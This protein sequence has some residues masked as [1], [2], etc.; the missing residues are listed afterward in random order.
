MG[1]ARFFVKEQYFDF[2]NREP[3]TAGWDYWTGQITGCGADTNCTRQHR[4]DVSNAFFFELEYQQTG[5]FV[6]RLYRAAYGNTQP[7][8]NSESAALPAYSAFVDDRSRIIGGL[9]LATA[10]LALANAFV[11]RAAF[12]TRYPASLTSAQFVDAVLANIQTSTGA[13]L[14]TQRTLLINL[15]DISGR[16]AVMYRLVDDSS[17]NPIANSAFLNAEYN[18]AFVLTQYFGYLR[19]DTDLAG[20]NFWLG[21][22]NRFPLRSA[23]GQNAMVCA[24]ITATEYQQRFNANATRANSEC[25]AVP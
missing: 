16:G 10:Q 24:F 15:A 3:D 13:D 9:N 5:A 20:F 8:P 22:V 19:R 17:S 12:T 21:I 1:T 14:T 6:Y 25:P 7:M 11:Q 2:L 4:V 23:T 18:K